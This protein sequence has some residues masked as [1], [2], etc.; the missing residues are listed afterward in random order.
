MDLDVIT[1]RNSSSELKESL[2][3]LPF[4]Q[5]QRY[6]D[7]WEVVQRLRHDSSRLRILDVGGGEGKYLSAPD[8]FPQDFV[9]AAD[10][11]SA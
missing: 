7:V 3:N 11:Q 6:R 1:H 2:L 5:Y 10:L 8:F 9:V 4:D